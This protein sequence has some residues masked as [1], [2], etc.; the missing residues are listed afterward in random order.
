MGEIQDNSAAELCGAIIGDGW[1]Q[2]NE[3][4][5]FLAGNPTEDKI[6][7]DLK[8]VQLFK[9]LSIDV[10]PKDF[11]YWGVYGISIHSKELIQ[12]FLNL[13]IPKGKKSLTAQIP[14]WIFRS[15]N[16]IK[17]SFI[18]GL[19]D[20]DGGISCQKDYT[21]YASDFNSKYHTK[22]RLRFTSISYKLQE[23]VLE[24]LDSLGYQCRLRSLRNRA[25]PKRPNNKDV[26]II[27]M[28]KLKDINNFFNNLIPSNQKH[29]T[30][31]NIWKQFGFCP[32]DTTLRQRMDILKKKISPYGLY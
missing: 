20:A 9:N 4:S 18:R 10:I 6:Y 14:Q 31:Y 24:L 19:F 7:Y 22:I 15:N 1:I 23:Q 13:G 27:A 2:S 25:T 29:I 30:K 8:V 5:L 21:K 26:H 17:S 3:K 12:R 16:A 11:S 28:D 32:P